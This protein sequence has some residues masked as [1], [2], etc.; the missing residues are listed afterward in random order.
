M[1]LLVLFN[2]GGPPVSAA[3]AIAQGTS[4]AQA[5]AAG[6]SPAAAVALGCAL[7]AA[8]GSKAFDPSPSVTEINFGYGTGSQVAS[9]VI[10][11]Q[12][13][14]TSGAHC[15]AFLMGDSTNEHN[16]IEHLI[17]PMR[18]VCSDIVAGVGFTITAVSPVRLTGSF[19]VHYVW[20]N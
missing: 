4:L 8:R 12:S 17:T 19:V 6:A 10:L 16:R 13:G 9:V 14:I 11:D 1:T 2:A 7:P 5:T 20:S 3:S 15:E 18:L